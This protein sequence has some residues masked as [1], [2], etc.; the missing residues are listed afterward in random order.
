MIILICIGVFSL[1]AFFGIT[2]MC[3]LFISKDQGA[4]KL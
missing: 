2:T 1:G 4:E 3:I